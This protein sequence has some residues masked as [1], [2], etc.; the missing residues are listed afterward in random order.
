MTDITRI[1]AITKMPPVLSHQQITNADPDELREMLWHYQRHQEIGICRFASDTGNGAPGALVARR[2]RFPFRVGEELTTFKMYRKN[3][4]YWISPFINAKGY[5]RLNSVVGVIF[6]TAD[7]VT[8]DGVAQANPYHAINA[9]TGA[10]ERIYMRKIAIGRNAMGNLVARDHTVIYLPG[11]YLLE[12]FHQK[13]LFEKEAIRGASMAAGDKPE[14]GLFYYPEFF[15][16]DGSS[17]GMVIDP[18]HKAVR[19]ALRT[20]HQRLKKAV[21]IATT[22]CERDLLKKMLGLPDPVISRNNDGTFDG[23]VAYVTVTGWV[24][25]ARLTRIWVELPARLAAATAA[26]PRG[27]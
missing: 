25:S 5:Y 11:E 1:A 6:R 13:G 22:H 16:P 24:A 17:I 20:Y 8:V 15:A 3:E 7:T 26:T 19:S 21:Q 23:Q 18:T 14:C 2:V 27:P 9:K 10:I 12:D 4:V